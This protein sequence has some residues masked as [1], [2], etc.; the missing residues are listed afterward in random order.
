LSEN[1]DK[2]VDDREDLDLEHENLTI[3]HEKLKVA[4]DL[5]L[6]EHEELKKKH[7]KCLDDTT[8]HDSFVTT[9]TMPIAAPT[10]VETCLNCASRINVLTST[11]KVTD[12]TN[13][14]ST[15]TAT[16][17]VD[18]AEH[19]K[20]KEE[21]EE[22]KRLMRKGLC[23]ASIG[24]Q[25]HQKIMELMLRKNSGQKGL[26]YFSADIDHV[27]PVAPNPL[28]RI[29]LAKTFVRQA[30]T[31]DNN[32]VGHEQRNKKTMSVPANP[33]YVLQQNSKEK[34]VAK[35]VGNRRQR[36][37]LPAIWVPKSVVACVTGKPQSYTNTGVT[38]GSHR[39][40]TPLCRV[41]GDNEPKRIHVISSIAKA[42]NIRNLHT[43]PIT[44]VSAYA[45]VAKG[46]KSIWVP[47]S[48]N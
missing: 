26:G 19:N 25:N 48:H 14:A 29:S 47:K 30:G 42:M 40:L 16:N 35:F 37:W 38:G 41:A 18:A 27:L 1:Y 36:K 6:K 15:S 45:K 12:N 7:A 2:V 33:S 3:A 46:T 24:M 23:T 32:Y 8:S 43:N 44:A 28:N 9:E 4:H 17:S 20:L 5:L 31:Y 34:V 22:L 13:E 39:L 21:L 11:G 10:V